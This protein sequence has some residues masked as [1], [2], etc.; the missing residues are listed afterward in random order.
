VNRD[1]H[2]SAVGVAVPWD[3]LD[4]S[5]GDVDRRPI[6]TAAVAET[7]AGVDTDEEE[8]VCV[9]GGWLLV[10]KSWS[11]LS[12]GIGAAGLPRQFR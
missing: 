10:E 3:E 2:R 4:D 5:L 1:C 11:L 6:K 7:Q 9:T 12:R 8:K